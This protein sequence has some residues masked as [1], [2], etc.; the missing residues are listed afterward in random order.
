MKVT[1]AIPNYKGRKLLEQNLPSVV[2]AGADQILIVDDAS[3]DGSVEFIQEN[4]P[5]VELLKGEQ[6]EGFIS[7]VNKLFDNA[8]GDIVVL[9]NNDVLVEK[10]FLKPLIPRFENEKVFAVSLHEKGEGYSK[11]LWKD[12]FFEYQ[13]GGEGKDIHKSSWASGGSAAFRKSYWQKLGGFD[14]IFYPG[15][16]E[17]IDISFRALKSGYEILWDPDALVYHNHESTMSKVFKKRYMEWVKQ[18][19]QLLF[20]WKN[21]TDKKLIIRHK[22]ELLKRLFGGMGLGY[23]IPF[24]WALL[25]YPAIKRNNEIK[26]ADLEVINYVN[27]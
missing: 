8:A 2:S 19:N 4:F 1:I 9:L 27:S 17:D 11:A 5:N 25:K 10:D 22:K 20:I 16:W 6:N 15:Y 24:L 7:S 3:S 14:P 18:R 23:W 26:R 12:G 13:R 21:I